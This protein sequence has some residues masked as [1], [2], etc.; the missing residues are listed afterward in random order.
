MKKN[1]YWLIYL[2]FLLPNV[3]FAEELVIAD[4]QDQQVDS[5]PTGWK[6]KFLFW[7]KNPSGTEPYVIAENQDN[8]YLRGESHSN[9]VTIDKKFNY[10]LKKYNYLSWRW[11]VDKLPKNA[12]E[13][14]KPRSDSAA[15]LY[16]VFKDHKTIKYVWSST[17]PPGTLTVSP[18]S[19][20]TKI[21]VI[22]SDE[23]EKGIW[24]KEKRNVVLDYKNVFKKETVSENPK[25]IAILTDS[26]ATKSSAI[27]SYDD[28]V[29]S[30]D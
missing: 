29:V 12:A 18:F 27:A 7:Y 15:G 26:D 5:F 25:G 23:Q 17:L 10:D 2:I 11:K 14:K 13:N 24:L 3:L 30:S 20:K 21:I 28:I 16:V 6:V 4:F 19:S 22:R 8:R 1:Y 9:A